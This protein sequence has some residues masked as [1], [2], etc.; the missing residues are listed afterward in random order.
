MST[1]TDATAPTAER[2]R[3][4]ADV[5]ARGMSARYED[6][7]HGVAGDP[8][9]ITLIDELPSPKR[10]P[11][12]VFSSARFLGAPMG[13]YDAFRDWLHEHWPDVRA[14]ALTHATQTNEAARC[15][16]HVPAMA[17]MEGPLALREVGASAGLWL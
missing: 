12:L 7:A 13:G 16:L 1:S 4:F 2:Y 15:A 9:T 17:G 10:Q 14:T 11:N 8:A 3:L 5:E 6:W